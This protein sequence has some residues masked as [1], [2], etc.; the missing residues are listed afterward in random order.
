MFGRNPSLP[1]IFNE[2][3]PALDNN[4]E[5][6]TMEEHLNIL[7]SAR[8]AFA[9]SEASDRIRRALKAKVD[10]SGD[11]YSKGD[12]VWYWRGGRWSKL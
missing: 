5:S 12:E 2:G 8:I 3:L 6:R 7:K 1:S 11:V 4:T 9:K 10:T